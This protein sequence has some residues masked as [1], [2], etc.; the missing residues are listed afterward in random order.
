MNTESVQ[1]QFNLLWYTCIFIFWYITTISMT[2]EISLAASF[3]LQTLK[4][5]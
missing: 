2:M 4:L 1:Q 3:C 5:I